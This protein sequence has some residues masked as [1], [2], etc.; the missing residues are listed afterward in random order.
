[1][2]REKSGEVREKKNRS[3]I[4]FVGLF[5][6]TMLAVAVFSACNAVKKYG[7][8]GK[9]EVEVEVELAN[10]RSEVAEETVSSG[11]EA[12]GSL[13]SS[14]GEKAVKG[15][16]NSYERYL[17]VSN[18]DKIT[19]EHMTEAACYSRKMSEEEQVRRQDLQDKY[20]EGE[21]APKEEIDIVDKMEDTEREVEHP[22]FEI[23]NNEYFLPERT[24]TDNRF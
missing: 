7:D 24:L 13:V 12:A 15:N 23:W 16:K 10:S 6:F 5:L 22:V 9:A 20:E 8:G 4:L 17:E 14:Q 19:K 1:M 11:E 3:I 18:P 2:K 21:L